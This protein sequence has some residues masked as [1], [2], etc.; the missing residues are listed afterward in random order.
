MKHEEPDFSKYVYSS[1]HST[2]CS[3][4]NSHWLP[5]LFFVSSHFLSLILRQFIL[6]LVFMPGLIPLDNLYLQS[7][8]TN[9]RSQSQF[10]TMRPH[11]CLSL[12][13]PGLM[14][15]CLFIFFIPTDLNPSL[16]PKFFTCPW[17]LFPVPLPCQS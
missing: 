2:L 7:C 10:S 6:V 13:N 17:L 4:H 14:S 5:V 15:Y 3:D 8:Q 11:S 16:P 12:P 9:P 1:L